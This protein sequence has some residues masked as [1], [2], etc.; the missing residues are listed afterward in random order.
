MD[1]PLMLEKIL[2]EKN[3]IKGALPPDVDETIMHL[4][5]LVSEESQS[6][7]SASKNSFF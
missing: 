1:I 5:S 7:A 2:S 6:I 3:P 4:G